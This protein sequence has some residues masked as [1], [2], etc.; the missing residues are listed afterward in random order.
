M[1]MYI[2]I[3]VVNAM[4]S[5][6]WELNLRSLVATQIILDAS[7][8]ESNIP[9]RSLL[10]LPRGAGGGV[11]ERKKLEGS[12]L[13]EPTKDDPFGGCGIASGIGLGS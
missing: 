4:V 9:R 13:S 12:G 2:Y 11:V 7:H 5:G 8:L 1:D 10:L 6:L 3:Y